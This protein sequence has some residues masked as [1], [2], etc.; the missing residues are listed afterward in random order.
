MQRIG[1]LIFGLMYAACSPS[2][3]A[4][5]AVEADCAAGQVCQDGACVQGAEADAGPV[6]TSSLDCSEPGH[7]KP[8][9]PLCPD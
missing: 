7:A 4:P 6:C 1:L 2:V 5:C 8:R 3:D 9:W